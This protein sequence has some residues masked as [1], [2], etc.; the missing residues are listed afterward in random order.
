MLVYLNVLTWEGSDLQ[1]IGCNHVTEA[2]GIF[3]IAP[4]PA[5]R[6]TLKDRDWSDI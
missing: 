6:C 4:R 3:F 2:D 1:R 5:M